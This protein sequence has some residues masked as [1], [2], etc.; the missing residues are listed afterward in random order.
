[1]KIEKD[2]ED[3][4]RLLNKHKVKYSI[5][6]SYAVA[7][8]AKPRYTKD[9]DIL[10]EPDITNSR[11]IIK[12]LN[13]FGF[14]SLELEANDFAQPGKIIQLGYEPVRVDIMT[15]IAG[16]NFEEVWDKKQVGVY[17]EEKVFFIGINELI[18]NKQNSNRK[19]DHVDLD[20]LLQTRN[21][22]TFG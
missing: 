20:I 12:A 6:G 11:R 17:G 13:E 8:Y 16:C 4:L 15:S 14:Q 21:S 19:Q 3:L 5:I 22:P 2:Y 9:I 1:M 10:V 7:F 18:K